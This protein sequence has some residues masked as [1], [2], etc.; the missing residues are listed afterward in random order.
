M[1]LRFHGSSFPGMST[2]HLLSH[3]RHPGALDLEIF[4]S[5][6]PP[7]SLS[8]WCKNCGIDI[9]I[10]VGYLTDMYYLHFDQSLHLYSLPSAA[11]RGLS[12]KG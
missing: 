3:I 1:L 6:L 4:P 11:K 8:L 7:C 12:N 2:R 10:R 9:L 5:L